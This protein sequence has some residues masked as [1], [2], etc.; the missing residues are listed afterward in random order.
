MADQ[1]K[2]VEEKVETEEERLKREEKKRLKEE[3]K[4][5]KKIEAKIR[6]KEKKKEKK[7]LKEKEPKQPKQ[8]KKKDA[9]V[10]GLTVKKSEKFGDWYSEVITRG[11]LIEYYDIS[12]CYILRPNAFAMWEVVR[13][14]ID[15][16]IKLLGVQNA[17]FPLF[18]TKKALETEKDHIAG[19]SPE[20]AW[21]TRSGQS[22]LAEPIAV[23][24][25]SET[26]MYPAYAK[27]I[28][29]HRDL[30]LRLNQWTNV[31]RWE[32][33]SA[34]PF[35]RSREFLWQEG[36]SA[37]ASYKEAEEEVYQILDIYAR[38]Y[39]ELLACPVIKGMKSEG[40][41]FAGG[42]YTTSVEGFVPTNGRAV[43][44]ATSHCLGQNFSKMFG[45]EYETAAEDDVNST[46]SK[47][48]YA[49]QNSWGFTTRSIGVCILVHGD[50]KGL[51][52]PPRVAPTQVVF[53]PLYFK[54][55]NK[56][57]LNAKAN[58]LVTLL[59]RAGI[60]VQL[61]ARD[62]K[63]PGFKYT[64]WEIKGVPLRI[65]FGPKD[66]TA[67]QVVFVRRTT[68]AKTTVQLS[69]N[70]TESVH[71]EL[72]AIQKEMFERAKKERD[73]S[74]VEVTKWEDFVP[75]LNKKHLCLIPWCETNE[76]EED[77]KKKSKIESEKNE[78]A[79]M[80]AAAKSINVPFAQRELKEGTLCICGQEAKKWA[81]F[82]RSY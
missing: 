42:L 66:L 82:G 34:V 75:E 35:I 37:F 63:T 74:I 7:K 46:A 4:A 1:N 78:D 2:T 15:R 36:H 8:A 29:S 57:E 25:T 77:I 48:E 44:A 64:E 60:R 13:D 43:Q 19:F 81:L 28:R 73:D 32:F 52:L 22:E 53:I 51:I 14:F 70:F 45:I 58:E 80:T 26:I 5:K 41:K 61:D 18:V 31:V 38:A 79:E 3:A 50:D 23:R 17:Y 67:G 68:N 33:K 62:N 27:W 55:T 59:K 21:V 20:V 9:D 65:E 69:D 10:G 72:E 40:E 24:P 6:E 76:C 11:E 39:E 16:E 49:W 12:G 56:E 71:N 47:R 54:D 30:P